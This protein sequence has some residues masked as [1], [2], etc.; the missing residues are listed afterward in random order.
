MMKDLRERLAARGVVVPEL[1]A[2]EAYATGAPVAVFE[3]EVGDALARWSAL[4]TVRPTS[5]GGH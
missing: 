1:R 2:V 5:A 4:R 3:S